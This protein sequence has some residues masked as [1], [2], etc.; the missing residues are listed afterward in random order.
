MDLTGAQLRAVL[1]EQWN[2]ANEPSTSRRILQ[3]SGLTYAW[4]ASEADKVDAD[5]IVAGTLQLD[6][7]GD[8]VGES[9]IRNATT[10]RVVVNSFL[11]DG[12]DNFATLTEGTNK[13]VGGLDIDALREYLMSSDPVSPTPTVRISQVP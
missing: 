5:A 9:P 7:D 12:G 11:S 8:G 3:V 1:N 13:L 10:Y 6:A 2:G 4:D